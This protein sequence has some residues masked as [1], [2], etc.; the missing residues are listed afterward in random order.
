MKEIAAC[1]EL[2]MDTANETV[3]LWK[4]DG[5][6]RT[7]QISELSYAGE[8]GEGY[9]IE[10]AYFAE[11]YYRFEYSPQGPLLNIDIELTGENIPPT[12]LYMD[13]SVCYEIN[14]SYTGNGE[15]V[16]QFENPYIDIE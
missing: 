7:D 8:T 11:M 15:I 14:W 9:T 2:V 6:V 1:S 3:Q 13:Y 16:F 4:I 10:K 5:G 12:A